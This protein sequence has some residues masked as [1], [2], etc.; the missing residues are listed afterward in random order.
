MLKILNVWENTF[1]Q[2]KVVPVVIFQSSGLIIVL[3]LRPHFCTFSSIRNCIFVCVCAFCSAHT[4]NNNRCVKRSQILILQPATS[5]VNNGLLLF[6]L[7]VVWTCFLHVWVFCCVYTSSNR[8]VKRSTRYQYCDQCP[9]HTLCVNT[10]V[11]LNPIRK[12][13]C[14]L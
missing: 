6:F 4:G 1:K 11:P 14:H 9:H 10:T 5:N 7:G 13:A 2:L 8:C 12:Q 3:L